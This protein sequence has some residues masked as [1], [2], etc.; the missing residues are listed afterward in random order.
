MRLLIAE[1]LSPRAA[2]FFT[3]NCKMELPFFKTREGKVEFT[4][5]IFNSP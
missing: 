5:P 2:M 1:N 4:S 3:D